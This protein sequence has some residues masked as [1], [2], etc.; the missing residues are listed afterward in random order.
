VTPEDLA[1]SPAG[2][3]LAFLAGVKVLTAYVVSPAGREMHAVER[4]VRC[5][6]AWLPPR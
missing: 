4:A 3:G 1:W 6:L 2:G 5:C